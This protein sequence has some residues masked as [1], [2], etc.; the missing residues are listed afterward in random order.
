MAIVTHGMPCFFSS[1]SCVEERMMAA[2][3]KYQPAW[4][5]DV[6]A[7]GSSRNF[8]RFLSMRFACNASISTPLSVSHHSS[9]KRLFKIIVKSRGT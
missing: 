6:S 9:S 3:F 7:P 8:P 2:T 5:I 1:F 4:A